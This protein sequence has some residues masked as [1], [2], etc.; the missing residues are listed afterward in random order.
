MSLLCDNYDSI[1]IIAAPASI[2]CDVT[3]DFLHKPLSTYQPS[4]SR[5]ESSDWK[6]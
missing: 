1:R 4:T 6:D 5:H 3:P 2:L